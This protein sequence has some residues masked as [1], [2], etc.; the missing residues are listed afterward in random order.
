[1][2]PV[3][4]K[5]APLAALAPLVTGGASTAW[6]DD[7]VVVR[8]FYYREASTRVIQPMVE[9]ERDSPSG[10]DVGAHFL[11]D[12]ITSASIAAGTNVDRV[13]TE[14]RS[15]AGLRIRKRWQR[16]DLTAA[17]RYS[18]ESDYWSHTV[19]LSLGRRFWGDTG[20]VRVS[21]GRGID[22]MTARGRIPD[23]R[24]GM[25]EPSC[26]L[27]V[28]FASAVYTQIL[29]PVLLAQLSYDAA[30]LD[31]F[32]GNLYRSVP[33]PGL[34]YE[35][36]PQRRMRNAVAPRIA[37]YIP[38]TGTGFQLHYRFYWDFYPGESAS[39]EEPWALFG[40]TVEGR[41]YQQL[42]QNLEL[43]LLYRQHVQNSAQFWCDFAANRSCY[44]PGQ[45]VYFSTDPKLG[46]LHT[47]YPEVK[48]VWDAEILRD[49]P[50][51]RWF[52]A[53]SFE[54]SY[55]YYFQNN[56]FGNAHVLQSGYRLPY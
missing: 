56:A 27:D 42:T 49:V 10:V 5:L 37:Y 20:T 12:A 7:Y 19:G 46:A 53:G 26:S 48:L 11:L 9:L 47:E 16:T 13:F 22:S 44:T 24:P 33:V 4:R 18:A 41:I 3:L 25:P 21:V 29:S 17:Y 40:H 50:F 15:E 1:M 35:V 23:C 8:G 52:A 32:Q 30:Y 31:G 43:R 28:W 55:G 2:K 36:L 34:G 45:S 51:F 39:G 14:T 38:A 54:V 6:A